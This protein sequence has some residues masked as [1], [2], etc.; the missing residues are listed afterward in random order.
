[1]KGK[2]RRVRLYAVLLPSRES[3]KLTREF[4]EK[5]SFENL[6]PRVVATHTYTVVDGVC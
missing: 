1:M 6:P 5:W 4:E 2:P 3:A